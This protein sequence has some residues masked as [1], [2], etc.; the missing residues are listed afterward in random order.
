M[1]CFDTKLAAMIIA[2]LAM[3]GLITTA[4]AIEPTVITFDYGTEGFDANPDCETIHEDGGN[5]GAFWNFANR[6]CDGDWV[7]RAYFDTRTS[8]NP[9]FVGDYTAKGP[10]RI[11]VDVNVNRYDFL[12]FWG[13]PFEVE[14]YRQL[15]LELIDYDDPYTDP[16]TGYSWPWT[17]VIY[18]AGYFPDRLDG[19]KNFEIDIADPTATE[20][21]EGWFGFGGPENPTTYM[22]Q[23]PPD[24]TFADVMAGVDE[25][26]LHSVEPGYFYSIGF[27]HDID[28][29]NL[30]IKEL[31]Q[32]CEGQ[33][34]TVYVGYDGIVVGGQFDGQVYSGKLNGTHED[35]IIVGTD[36]QD[37]IQGLH[38]NDLICAGDGNDKVHGGQGADIMF[39]EE[40]DDNLLGQQGTDFLHGGPGDDMVNGG[41]GADT[42]VE[43]SSFHLCGE[44]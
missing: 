24:R 20:V 23:L 44:Y 14:E 28:F 42:C 37:D 39:G 12:S 2:G 35:D 15:V 31:P 26:V 27:L 41:P 34:A 18:A 11:S 1:K 16:D 5:P 25:I 40:G 38:G 19:W 8:T 17:S 4:Q 30:T 9:A 13:P 3:V 6:Y 43:A 21:P 7:V 10:V 33:E 22:P 32:E 29:D 36:A